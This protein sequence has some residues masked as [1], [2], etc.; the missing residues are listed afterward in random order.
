MAVYILSYMQLDQNSDY[1][2]MHVRHG[3]QSTCHVYTNELLIEEIMHKLSNMKPLK[4]SLELL[5]S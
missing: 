3:C 1:K 2:C 5:I 4:S